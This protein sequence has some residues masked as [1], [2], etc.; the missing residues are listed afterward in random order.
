MSELYTVQPGTASARL[1]HDAGDEWRRFTHHRFVEELKAGTL[2]QAAFRYY[3]VQDYR[4]LVHFARAWA[5]V[6]VKSEDVDDIRAAVSVV[7]TLIDD[8][9]KLHVETCAGWGLDAEQLKTTPED[10][11]NAAYTRFVLERGFTGDLADLLVALMPCV[12]GY[13]EIGFRLA[14]DPATKRVGNPYDAWIATYAG[15]DYQSGAAAAVAQLERVLAH[16]L[17]PEPWTHPRWHDLRAGFTT[18]TR[19]EI[20]FWEMGLAAR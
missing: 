5:L 6:A 15:D 8:E 1:V 10:P 3:L 16:R 20:G 4:F 18:A 2:D 19:L 7:H 13:A 17:G 12:I 9:L 11:A 14:G